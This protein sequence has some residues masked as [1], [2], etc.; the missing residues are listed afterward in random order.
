MLS[1]RIL[2]GRVYCLLSLFF[3]FLAN[4][5]FSQPSVQSE[6]S[7][8]L[9]HISAATNETWF[10]WI[11]TPTLHLRTVMR[12][13]RDHHGDALAG[14]MTSPD[15][16][17]KELA[18]GDLKAVK[19]GAWSFSV[20]NPENALS[21]ATFS[22]NQDSTGQ[23]VG[24]LTQGGEKISLKL[25]RID[26][27]PPETANGLGADSVWLGML[28]LVV[29]KQEFRF[30]VYSN[31]PFASASA[32]RFLFDILSQNAIGIPAE[33]TTGEDGKTILEMKTIG[34]KFTGKLNE[35]GDVLFG[36]FVQGN[37]PFKLVFNLQSKDP[38]RNEIIKNETNKEVHTSEQANPLLLQGESLPAISPPKI[39]STE[40]FDEVPFEVRYGAA[41][42]RK[43]KE[44]TVAEAGVKLA[45]TVT[46]PKQKNNERPR[47]FPAVVM[48]TGNGPQD[49]NETIGRHKPFEKIAH[50][51]AENGVASLRYD[52]RGVGESTGDLLS[53][54]SEDF[55]KDAIAVWKHARSL[56]EID[57]SRVGL[58]GH[59]EGGL[60]G[61]IAAVWEPEV[62]F[63]I[64]IAPPGVN[65]SEILKSQIDRIALLEGMSLANRNATLS[66]QSRLQDIAG[67]YFSDEVTMRRDIQSAIK[68]SWEGLKSIALSQDP[69]VNL[70]DL[71]KEISNQ[72]E[73]QFQ[74]LRSP[75]YRFFLNYEPTSNWMIMRCPTLAIWGS[76]DVQVLPELNRDKL[77]KAIER[78]PELD[79]QLSV[80]P[81]LNHLLQ[82]SQSGL[83]D[84][85]EGIDETVSPLA[86]QAIRTW[87][88]EHG[89]MEK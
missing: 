55:A 4:S 67:G 36:R 77:K 53:V 78:N 9:V 18:L 51:L 23:V 42:L 5:A 8:S 84:E 89:L 40:H 28:D 31:P 63:L 2:E 16:N 20:T 22:G 59:S 21:T 58:L 52:D 14:S 76:N 87:A 62:A 80:L 10:G 12:I 45:G 3:L 26:S 24:E 88:L 37:A 1:N 44:P 25:Q 47:K 70:D 74:Q 86:L 35:S 69:S 71:K 85:Y 17:G 61:P 79:A 72:I 75:W 43:G 39:V 30:R 57:P 33:F 34:A 64:L 29:R 82:T 65:G 6:S 49:R 27:M 11:E 60:V 73:E 13:V 81:G 66:L 38:H 46:I 15:Q 19:D 83:P 54:T 41:K 32:P 7:A 68:Q 48:V 50:F 56:A